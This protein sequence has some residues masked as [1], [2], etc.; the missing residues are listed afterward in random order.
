MREARVSIS[1]STV[2]PW[3]TRMVV[4]PEAVVAVDVLR[5]TLSRR[6]VCHMTIGLRA[7]RLREGSLAARLVGG[8]VE[9]PRRHIVKSTCGTS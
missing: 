8:V 6:I 5:R 1:D 7:L 4:H 9:K 2:T 3:R